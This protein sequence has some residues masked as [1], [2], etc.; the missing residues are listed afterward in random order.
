MTS[1]GPWRTCAQRSLGGSTH[2]RTAATSAC[3]STRGGRMQQQT[4]SSCLGNRHVL[5]KLSTPNPVRALKKTAPDGQLGRKFFSFCHRGSCGHLYHLQCLQQK[6]SGWGFTSDVQQQWS[7]YKCSS[8][9]GGRGA[10]ADSRGRSL[11]LAQVC[12]L[13]GDAIPHTQVNM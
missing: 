13:N 2:D 7:C 10:S 1:T 8:S 3:S 11:S 12:S 9:K 6:D 4:R 5:L